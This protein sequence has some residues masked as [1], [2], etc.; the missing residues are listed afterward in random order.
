MRNKATDAFPAQ[1]ALV[2]MLILLGL[3][4]A[5]AVRAETAATRQEIV[6]LMDY[7]AASECRFIRNGKVYDAQTAREHIQKKYDYLQSRIRSAE[8]FI[9]FAASKSS[10]SGEPYRIACGAKTVLCAEWLHA[11]LLRFRRLKGTTD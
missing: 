4:G 3:S 2:W 9:R 5:S 10:M 6:H 11:E 1:R 7:I 8:D